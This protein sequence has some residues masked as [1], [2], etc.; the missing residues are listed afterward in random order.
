MQDE[1]TVKTVRSVERTLRILFCVA[2]ARQP[3]GLSEIGAAADVDKAT[4]MRLL[5][6]LV[7]F[8]LVNRDAESRKYSIGAGAWQLTAALQSDLRLVAEPHLR[9]L[10]ETTGESAS[11]IVERGLQRVVLTAVEATHELRVVPATNAVV[12]IYA[13]ASGKVLMAFMPPQERDR[14]IEVT[15]LKPV[16][17]RGLTDRKSFLAALDQVR[18][19]GYAVTVGDVTLG[20]VAVAAPILDVNG[21]VRA[22]VSLRGPE[23]RMTSERIDLLAKLVVE[24]AD[25]ISRELFHIP[26]SSPKVAQAT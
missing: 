23:A 17:E 26:A 24:T 19:D 1:Q 14:I 20:A 18:A 15:G 16:N 10:Q 3:M 21:L 25:K 6:T 22:V 13:G 2:S 9:A 12:P 8:R 7:E 4:A 11:L 5:N